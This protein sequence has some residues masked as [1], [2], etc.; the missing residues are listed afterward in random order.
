MKV[1]E[2][3]DPKLVSPAKMKDGQIGI[4]RKWSYCDAEGRI[5]QKYGNSMLIALGQYSGQSFTTAGEV[6]DSV[7]K[8]QILPPG[9]KLEI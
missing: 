6:D 1:I 4:I 2:I 9:S 8:I 7:C 5:V 3:A